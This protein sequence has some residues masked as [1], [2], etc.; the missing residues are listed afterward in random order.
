FGFHR[1][2]TLSAFFNGALL[3]PMAGYILWKSYQRFLNPVEIGIVPTITI[4]FGGLLV[5]LFSVYYLQ[6][7]GMSLNPIRTREIVR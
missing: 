4:G 2:E 5:N 7:G 1:I 6:G 3:I